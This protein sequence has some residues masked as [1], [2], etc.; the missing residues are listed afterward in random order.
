[1]SI[2]QLVLP[3]PNGCNLI[4]FITILGHYIMFQDPMNLGA[5]L[6]CSYYLGVDRVIGSLKR[7]FELISSLLACLLTSNIHTLAAALW[8]Q[9]SARQVQ[10]LWSWCPS[11]LSGTWKTSWRKPKIMDGA[12]WERHVRKRSQVAV[13]V[14]LNK[15]QREEK[16]NVLIL[17]VWSTQNKALHFWS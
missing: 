12:L 3:M 9:P 16:T 8:V 17:T 6:R 5:I 14:P 4:I 2:S 1:M 15:R 13:K 7:W 10:E 11:T